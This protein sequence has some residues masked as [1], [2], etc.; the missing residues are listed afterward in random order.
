MRIGIVSEYCRPWPGGISEHVHHEAIELRRRGHSVLVVSGGGGDGAADA[1]DDVLRLGKAVVFNS[2]G[3][4]SRLALG[5][6][7]WRMQREL[8]ALRLDVLHV[9]APFDPCL[10][11]TAA[12]AAP[13]PVV[14]TFHASFARTPLF[15]VIYGFSPLARRAFRQLSRRIAVSEEARRSVQQYLPGEY[16]LI[17]NGVDLE[18]FN[19]CG[20]QGAERPR[21]L[22]VGRAD[23]RKGLPL[24]VQAH[25]LLVARG[26]ALELVL[27][28]VEPSEAEPLLR[29]LP[30][31]ARTRVRVLGYVTPADLPSHYAGASL[32]CS[33]ATTGESQGVVW[34]EAMA[35]GKPC[36][37]FD[38]A[39]Y[40]EVIDH[41]RTGLLVREHTA[42]ALA[43][44]LEQ[45]LADRALCERMGATGR[46]HARRY[47]WPEVAQR[48]EIEL[49][50]AAS[51]SRLSVEPRAC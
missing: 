23:P 27:V 40:R 37:G 50:A 32:V 11:L 36:V 39:G 30:S 12:L 43:Q 33:P 48:I 19:P 4:R 24:L 42:H 3:A 45:L 18:R 21:V 26:V 34:L 47:A 10:P 51:G 46:S 7:L 2:N 16:T 31:A 14:G 5:S 28:G 15:D 49:I 20:P 1:R 6:F 25:A 35:S 38:I 29:A 17:P 9:H 13:C 44:A 8:R 22:F 41:G